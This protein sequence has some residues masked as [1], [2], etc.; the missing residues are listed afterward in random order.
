MEVDCYSF[1]DLH[2]TVDADK[3]YNDIVISIDGKV[4]RRH[5]NIS[6]E[7]RFKKTEE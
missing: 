1:W 2:K 7:C 4:L 3:I 6:N 5:G